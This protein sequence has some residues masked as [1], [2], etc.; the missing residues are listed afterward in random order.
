MKMLGDNST[1]IHGNQSTTKF[2]TLSPHDKKYIGD[3]QRIDMAC[4][5]VKPDPRFI[6]LSRWPYFELGLK[7]ACTIAPW[8]GKVGYRY[9]KMCTKGTPT[10]TQFVD[11]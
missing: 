9:T 10:I 5:M 8:I 11:Q 6:Y 1:I 4:N 2:S 7:F 3:F